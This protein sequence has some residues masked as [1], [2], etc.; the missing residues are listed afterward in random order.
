MNP[1][2]GLMKNADRIV[3]VD[4][5]T[6]AGPRR[7]KSNCVQ[8]LPTESKRIKSKPTSDVLQLPVRLNETVFPTAG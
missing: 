7:K 3:F 8:Q 6:A 2:C 1:I 4:K 5:P